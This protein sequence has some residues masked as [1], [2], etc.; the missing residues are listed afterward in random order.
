MRKNDKILFEHLSNMPAYASLSSK[1]SLMK[2]LTKFCS[3]LDIII[4]A[5]I[6][7]I[8]DIFWEES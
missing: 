1:L 2:V 3:L 6:N 7:K 5:I 4:I 8:S